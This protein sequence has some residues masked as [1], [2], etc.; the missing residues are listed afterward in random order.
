MMKPLGFVTP[1][2]QKSWKVA[3]CLNDSHQANRKIVTQLPQKRQINCL[4]F[5]RC[6]GLCACWAQRSAAP[7]IVGLEGA[8][9]R[10][11]H[12]EKTLRLPRVPCNLFLRIIPPA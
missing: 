4:T 11:H 10:E 9:R 2:T 8:E 1:V 12:L 5:C 6:G 3:F 7:L